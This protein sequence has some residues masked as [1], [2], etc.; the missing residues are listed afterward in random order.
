MSRLAAL[1][2]VAI[3]L[4][5]CEEEFVPDADC[6]C[7]DVTVDSGADG[8][9]PDA[10]DTSE[11][12]DGSADDSDAG[13]DLCPPGPY[14]TSVGDRLEGFEFTDQ[15]EQ[16]LS[17][18]DIHADP[19]ARLLL[20]S[21]SAEW[22]TAC[23]EEQP[24]LQALAD[25]YGPDG[26]R[27]LVTLFEDANFGPADT[28]DVQEWRELYDLSLFTVL[29]VGNSFSPFYDVSLTPMNMFV[30]VD[31]AA[32]NPMEILSIEVGALNEQTAR[33]VIELSL[34]L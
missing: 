15:D 8:G 33:T 34:G 10:G 23:R 25:E 21:T 19:A 16:P 30:S 29:D 18:C 11:P 28:Q 6:D 5:S 1:C 31:P 27:V 13:S 12:S 2:A 4:A 7:R 9:A 32:A 26:F 3:V 17:L 20:I 22:C 24:L 14:G